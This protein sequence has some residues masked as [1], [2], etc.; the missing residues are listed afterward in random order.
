MEQSGLLMLVYLKVMSAS[1]RFRLGN[2]A[3][4]ESLTR[5]LTGLSPNGR[6]AMEVVFGG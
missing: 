6:V 3:I 2:A 1:V 5:P 4:K